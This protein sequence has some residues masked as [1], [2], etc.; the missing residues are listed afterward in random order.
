MAT[1]EQTHAL[2]GTVL[3]NHAELTGLITTLTS[4]TQAANTTVTNRMAIMENLNV[5]AGFAGVHARLEALES[6][7][8]IAS[9]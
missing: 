6:A 4:D 5:P 3:A 2:N 8:R 7:G 9:N 1:V